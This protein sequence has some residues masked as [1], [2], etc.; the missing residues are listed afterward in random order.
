MTA[1]AGLQSQAV[2]TGPPDRFWAL[3]HAVVAEQGRRLRRAMLIAV[4]AGLLA[5]FA[6]GASILPES[7]TG[8]PMLGYVVFLV[9]EGVVLALALLQQ[10][11]GPYRHALQV[12]ET[13]RR[14]SWR[15]W[16]EATGEQVPPLTPADAAAWLARN[17][18]ETDNP[19]QRVHAQMM[20]GDLAG[21]RRSLSHYPRETAMER[22]LHAS[23][24]WFLDFVDGREAGLETLQAP[25][26]EVQDP[27]MRGQAAAGIA[28][29]QG[30][31]AAARGGD[32]ISPLA[33]AYPALPDPA[34]D[35]WRLPL[36]VRTWTLTMAVSSLMI[37]AALLLGRW[38]NVIL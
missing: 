24:E 2:P 6:L 7:T 12:G 14:A 19:T 13:L 5:V 33:A 36:L 20:V 11:G 35:D 22:Y 21:A 23:Q 31:V 34:E 30:Y 3:P 27:A 26:A 38:M 8:D 32:W 9:A 28:I 10:T 29:L 15:S 17:P 16:R 18:D 37:G 4:G 1:D 25:L